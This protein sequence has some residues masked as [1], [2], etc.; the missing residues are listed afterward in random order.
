MLPFCASFAIWPVCLIALAAVTT[1]G[2]M[3]L[4]A[5]L[6]QFR[7]TVKSTTF[8]LAP[9]SASC[10][11]LQALTNKAVAAILN[12]VPLNLWYTVHA[13]D[14]QNMIINATIYQDEDGAY[15]AEVPSLPGC[16]SDGDTFDEAVANIREAAELWLAAHEEL[17]HCDHVGAV[18]VAL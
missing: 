3:S 16:V 1:S 5:S 4:L 10:R 15:C 14:N 7:A 9:S 18:I 11:H 13:K 12:D 6:P 8:L 2:A 17:S